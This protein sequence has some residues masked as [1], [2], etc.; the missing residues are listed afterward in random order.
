MY[1]EKTQIMNIAGLN[2]LLLALSQRGIV[3]YGKTSSIEPEAISRQPYRQPFYPSQRHTHMELISRLE[4]EPAICINGDWTIYRDDKVKVFAPGAYHTEHF[5]S[6]DK[7]YKLL[8]CTITTQTIFFHITAYAPLRGYSTSTKRLALNPPMARKLWESAVN[9]ELETSATEQAGFHYLLM[10][11]LYFC[12]K[13]AEIFPAETLEFHQ[14]VIEQLK[15]HIEDYYWDDITLDSLAGVVHY[16]PG[17]LNSL[18]KKSAGVPLH[19]YIN[20]VRMKKAGELLAA[21]S[22]LV[23]QAA[24][25]VGIHD[26]LYFSKKFR[27]HFGVSPNK[28]TGKVQDQNV[29]AG[30]PAGGL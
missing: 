2:N 4:G 11:A 30:V 3:F 12:V 29:K 25:A 5:S 28:F 17:H 9:T 24:E 19:R 18:F 23:R 27:R 15:R 8:W 7:P 10:E 14:Q 21:G 6:S 1:M 16:S 26:P 20:E 13:N 22:V